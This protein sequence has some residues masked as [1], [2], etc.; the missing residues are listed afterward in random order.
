[1]AAAG[2]ITLRIPKTVGERVWN[3]GKLS[4]GYARLLEAEHEV[5][6]AH[7]AAE[8]GVMVRDRGDGYS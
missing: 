5:H 1:M 7:R 6:V 8:F 4:E 3:D 2:E